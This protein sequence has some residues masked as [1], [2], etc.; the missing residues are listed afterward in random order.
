MLAYLLI[1]IACS[2]EP[3]GI[4]SAGIY[5]AIDRGSPSPC[6]VSVGANQRLSQGTPHASAAPPNVVYSASGGTITPA[7][8]YTAPPTAGN[9]TITA[10]LAVAGKGSLSSNTSV[11]VS[12]GPTVVSGG[13]STEAHPNEP[14]G[15]TRIA[16]NGFAGP[17]LA[18]SA[19]AGQWSGPWYGGPDFTPLVVDETNPLKSANIAKVLWPSGL[20]AGKSPTAFGGWD[21]RSS[22]FGENGRYHKVYVSMRVKIPSPDFQNQKVGTKLWYL[23]HG[24]TK[25]HNADF[26]LMEGTYRGTSIQ[27]AMKLK[28][29]ISPADEAVYPGSKG[30]GQNVSGAPLLTCGRWHQVEVYLD[31]GSVDRSNG[32]VRLW[33]DGTKVMDY[34]GSVQFLDSRYGFTE[35]FYDFQFTPVWGGTGGTRTRK[36]EMWFNSIYISGT[37]D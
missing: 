27:A 13:A 18:G 19:L 5:E 35:G 23:A 25:Q 6:G 9:F 21:R 20:P 4:L 11:S 31:Q 28:M 29:F 30:Y 16:E 34:T 7:G 15:F 37:K 2:A 3:T 14:A 12:P 36:D 1:L 24:N 17:T 22:D 26:L 33:V 32:T 10:R 8:L